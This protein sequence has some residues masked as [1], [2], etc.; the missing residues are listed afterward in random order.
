MPDGTA[1]STSTGPRIAAPPGQL[2]WLKPLLGRQKRWTGTMDLDQESTRHGL[3][4]T[5]KAVVVGAVVV[6]GVLVLQDWQAVGDESYFGWFLI[7][8]AIAALVL[9]PLFITIYLSLRE[10]VKRVLIR[11]DDNRVIRP[12]PGGTSLREFALGL[13]GWLDHPR[14]WAATA[15]ATVL[16]FLYTLWDA[17]NEMVS[18]LARLLIA[19][20]LVVQTALFFLGVL[21]I[22]QLGVTCW[23]IGWLLGNSKVR[24]R[25]LHP[26][27]C[28]GLRP[29]GHMLSVVL[30]AAAI[31]GG[32]SLGMFLAIQGTPAQP[33][34]RLEPYLLALLYLALLPLAF[35][36]LL[37]WPHQGMDRYRK[38]VLKPVARKF[39]DTIIPA[40]PSAADDSEQ[41]K[42]KTDSLS[43]ISRQF[44]VLDDA[45]PVWPL[46]LR[47]LQAVLAAAVLPVVIPVVTAVIL[48]M[49]TP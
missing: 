14:V 26:D 8:D 7:M 43:E 20:T 48:R 35:L 11:L 25:P 3:R 45:L 46:R 2:G 23:R 6:G 22:T 31:L 36:N 19:S 9:A 17:L 44:Q 27:G 29:V 39:N 49:L 34:R 33:T 37:W 32:A 38:Q 4:T 41:L 47:R 13:E 24:T 15:V 40:R 18:P 12:A 21:A 42:A 16:Y 30:S 28:G 5:W 10:F 1:Q